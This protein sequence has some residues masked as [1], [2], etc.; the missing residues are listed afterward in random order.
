[1]LV[2]AVHIKEDQSDHA[3][4][5]DTA[6]GAKPKRAK[7]EASPRSVTPADESPSHASSPC[8]K[9]SRKERNR[10]A[11][12]KL[13]LKKLNAEATLSAEL[14]VLRNEKSTLVSELADI[15]HQ[16]AAVKAKMIEEE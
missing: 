1:M 6:T 10:I 4:I 13:R 8:G 16:I 14:L 2:T 12:E 15:E 5:T 7:K 9:L 3:P 11:S